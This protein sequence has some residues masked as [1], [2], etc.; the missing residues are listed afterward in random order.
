MYIV[1]NKTTGMFYVN[2]H[3]WTTN[4]KSAMQYANYSIAN[5]VLMLVSNGRDEF[6]VVKL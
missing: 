3:E 1:Q 6:E 4:P 2:E 5:W